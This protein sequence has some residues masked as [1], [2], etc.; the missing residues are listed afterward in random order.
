MCEKSE[1]NVRCGA[2]KLKSACAVVHFTPLPSGRGQPT[3]A[4]AKVGG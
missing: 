2:Q 1:V 4:L 3:E